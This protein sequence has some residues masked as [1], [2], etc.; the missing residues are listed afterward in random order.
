MVSFSLHKPVLHFHS[1][2]LDFPVRRPIGSFVL[3]DI[4]IR[5]HT[6]RVQDT[7]RIKESIK[8][9][10]SS[11]WPSLAKARAVLDISFVTRKVKF[12]SIDDIRVGAGIVPAFIYRW[13]KE[14]TL[15]P[16]NDKSRFV[17]GSYVHQLFVAALDPKTC[18]G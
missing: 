12:Q 2:H 8:Q 6:T 3:A 14:S 4:S 10:F 9:Q 11:I 16:Q 18:E 5:S 15:I 17:V 1:L 7:S 13:P